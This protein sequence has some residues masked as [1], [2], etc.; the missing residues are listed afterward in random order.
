M[1]CYGEYMLALLLWRGDDEGKIRLVWRGVCAMEA[2]EHRY[3]GCVFGVY[4]GGMRRRANIVF[5]YFV[6]FCGTEATGRIYCG[7]VFF[8]FCL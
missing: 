4:V 2:M 1:R 6:C 8:C 3:G 7:R 5:V